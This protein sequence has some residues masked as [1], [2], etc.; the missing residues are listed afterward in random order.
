[1]FWQIFV[2]LRVFFVQEARKKAQNINGSG[3]KSDF[4]FFF[5]D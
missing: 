5:V 3:K 4:C 1:M 2:D